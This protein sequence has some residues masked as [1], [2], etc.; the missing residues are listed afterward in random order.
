MP[1][2]MLKLLS[3]CGE[4]IQF[5]KAQTW[6]DLDRKADQR[7]IPINHSYNFLNRTSTHKYV[8]I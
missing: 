6:R 1:K 5:T 2:K 3:V 4:P 7:V 8:A